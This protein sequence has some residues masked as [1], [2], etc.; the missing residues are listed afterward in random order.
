MHYKLHAEIDER[1]AA[2]F[3]RSSKPSWAGEPARRAEIEDG[4]KLGLH[5]FGRLYEETSR[6]GSPERMITEAP[7]LPEELVRECHSRQHRPLALRGAALRLVLSAWR[8][9]SRAGAAAKDLESWQWITL[10]P[11]YLLAAA[12]LHG[13][14][15]F[16]HE[17]VHGTLARNRWINGVFGALCAIPV[18]QNFSAYRVLH[19]RHHAHLGDSQRSKT[20]TPPSPAGPGSFSHELGAAA[21]RVSGLYH[22]DP[23][24]GIQ[25]RHGCRPGGDPR[26]DCRYSSHRLALPC[27]RSGS[28]APARLAGSHAVHQYR[29]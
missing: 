26:R 7:R 1:H 24:F 22:H 4:V 17:A 15:L 9:R 11:L 28:M 10:A 16:T 2:E 27:L 21:R 20:T 8:R 25:A 18:L 6:R 3:F 5:V 19:L 12:S 29:W 23:H 13:I 14:S